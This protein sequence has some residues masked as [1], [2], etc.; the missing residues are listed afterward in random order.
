MGAFGIL[1]HN[2]VLEEDLPRIPRNL[3]AR[4][5]RAVATRLTTAPDRYGRRLRRSLMGLWRLRVGDYRVIY[6]IEAS[7]VRIWMVA[8]RK[9]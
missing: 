7:R 2:L 5:R 3:H 9:S 6:E 8:H 4:I 1:Y